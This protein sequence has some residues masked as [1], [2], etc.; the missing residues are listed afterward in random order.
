MP[1]GLSNAPATFQRVMDLVAG[2]QW[3]QLVLG[4]MSIYMVIHD[5][6]VTLSI[7]L[8]LKQKDRYIVIAIISR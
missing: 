3:S 7:L 8:A 1:F 4:G 2:L 5:I 6:T